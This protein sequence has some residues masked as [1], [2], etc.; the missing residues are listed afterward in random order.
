MKPL[1]HWRYGNER[2][3]IAHW[4]RVGA[5]H[6]PDKVC[7]VWE[8]SIP[9]GAP[10]SRLPIS[11]AMPEESHPK[12]AVAGG[13]F[14]EPRPAMKPLS[15]LFLLSA[16]LTWYMFRVPSVPEDP[17]YLDSNFPTIAASMV[18]RTSVATA[19][20]IVIYEGLPHHMWEEE[21][22][23]VEVR[24]EDTLKIWGYTFYTPAVAP[25]QPE[26]FRQL[27]GRADSLKLYS[28]NKFCGGYHP[29]YAI[30]WSSGG[31]TFYA[32]V[33]IGCHEIVF[34]D[35]EYALIYDL[36]RATYDEFKRLL[37]FHQN[38]RPITQDH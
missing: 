28:G 8:F 2:G 34:F 17:P 33:C 38:K 3:G 29:D 4:E 19:D 27:L 20:S 21:L 36:P 24:R 31:T 7:K 18:Y 1:Y 15:V 26:V 12:P 16:T 30:S 5:G 13:L 32:L 35:G 25:A 14:P 11:R 22:L 10:E 23:E 37:G 6:P 9:W